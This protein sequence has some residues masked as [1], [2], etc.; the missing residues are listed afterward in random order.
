MRST[1]G[2][3][4]G[5]MKTLPQHTL[6]FIDSWLRLR[7]KWDDVPGFAVA[8]SKQGQIIF[9]KAYGHAD[10][11]TKQSMTPE[12]VFRIASHSKSFTATA[13]LQLQEAGKLRIDDPVA[14][15]LPWLTKHTDT[16]WQEVTIRQLLSHS[17]GVIRDGLDSN[18]WQL[19]REFP[20]AAE[21]QA[22]ILEAELVSEPNV[23]MKYSNYG[24]GLLGSVIEAV[25][26]QPYGEYV[27][28]HIVEPLGMTHTRPEYDAAQQFATGY[29]R[30]KLD[31]TRV[32][33]PHVPT[34][35][36]A[37][38]TGFSS[39]AADLCLF[40]D[41]LRVGTGLLLSDASKREMQRKQWEVEGEHGD[42]YGLGLD[43]AQRGQRTLRG[44]SGGFPGYVTRSWFDEK[45]GLVV[46]VL[47][48]AH[49]SRPAVMAK[50][51]ID[52]IDEFG[53]AAPK[54]EHRKFEGRFGGMHGTYQ[55]IAQ[56]N[57]L[58]GIW[59]NSWWPL[60]MAETLEVVDDTTL[61]VTKASGFS[62]HG[63]LITYTFNDDGSVHHIINTGSYS[64]PTDDG[65]FVPTWM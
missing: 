35:A 52:L 29:S 5:A 41:A 36:L 40:F 3:Y 12:H 23:R 6:D 58:R 55:V 48:N 34:K 38:A 16:R 31:K 17:A 56:P 39:T 47:C 22:A 27:T 30:M 18:Y 57:G 44:H 45:D 37:S 9:D 62:N 64:E 43:V 63:E 28:E 14:T 24:Y 25:S 42:A 54:A 13:V 50:A 61:R 10:I 15:Y 49:G 65:D 7:V 60:D 1:G 26:G 32:A 21:L 51:I 4:N 19:R 33:F 59:P 46:T 53:D 11:D 20:D 2:L 8:I